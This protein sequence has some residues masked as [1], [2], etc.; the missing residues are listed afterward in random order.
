MCCDGKKVAC[1]WATNISHLISRPITKTVASDC[2]L[3]HE[4]EHFDDIYNCKLGVC[5][6]QLK[7]GGYRFWNTNKSECKSYKK[8]LTCLEGKIELCQGDFHCEDWVK[9]RMESVKESID[10]YCTGVLSVL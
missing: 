4:A 8:E 10:Y 7:R 3:Q 2:V 5:V 1:V 9:M 6:K